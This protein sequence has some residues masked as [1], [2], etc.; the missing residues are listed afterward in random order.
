[1]AMN[2]PQ[3]SSESANAL[4]ALPEMTALDTRGGPPAG[5]ARDGGNT[6]AGFLSGPG[7]SMSRRVI[8]LLGTR[9]AALARVAQS[10]ETAGRARCA[11]E[12]RKHGHQGGSRSWLLRLLIGP[13]LAAEALTAYVGMEVLVASQA[14]AVGLSVLTALV[15]TGMACLLANR[16]LNGLGVPVT[17][18]ILEGTFVAVLT[19]LRFESLSVQGAGYPTAAG[20]AALAALISAL[21]LIGIE[22]IIFET[23]TFAIFTGALRASWASWR[24]TRAVA[25]LTATEA[26]ARAA[27]AMLQRR[28][29]DYLLRTE[30]LPV[31]DAEGRAAALKSA[32]IRGEGLS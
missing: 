18:R 24:R 14:L 25:D 7:K 20:A 21:A 9:T 13:G 16:R 17:A 2:Y 4:R 28:Y 12:Q 1:M 15:G 30:G 32:L 6:E 3:E 26:A 23:H 11:A 5:P 10:E 27:G 22:E 31:E 19:V 8:E 29:L